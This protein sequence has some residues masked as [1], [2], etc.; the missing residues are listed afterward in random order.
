MST[1]KRLLTKGEAFKLGP[2]RTTTTHLQT[3]IKELYGIGKV[4]KIY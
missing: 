1:R 2:T 4:G 3:A